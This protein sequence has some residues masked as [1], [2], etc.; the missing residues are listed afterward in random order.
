MAP[1]GNHN[2]RISQIVFLSDVPINQN[3]PIFKDLANLREQ[4]YRDLRLPP[5]NTEIW[6]YLFEDKARY[7]KFMHAKHPELPD[8]RAFFVA[9]ARRL[10]GV[11][12]LMVYTYLGDRIHQDLR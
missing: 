5:S 12:D 3:L 9:Q 8:R 11:E 2:F 7:E 6:V 1:P 4:V 10:G